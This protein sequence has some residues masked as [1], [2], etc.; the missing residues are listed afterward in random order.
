MASEVLDGRRLAD[1]LAEKVRERVDELTAAGLPAP[2]LATVLVGGDPASQ[3]YVAAK[4]RACARA[5]LR[6]F[7]HELPA[8]ATFAEVAGCIE[9]LNED[10]DVSGILLQ[11]PLPAGLRAERLIDLIDPA[12][13]VDGLSANNAGLV[14]QERPNLAPCTP[15]G[16]VLLLEQHGI[17]IEGMHVVIVG[18]SNLVGK[19]LASLLL[20][21]DATVTVC[22]HRTRDL[23]SLT[24]IADIVVAACG[25]PRLLGADAIR[26]GAVV[27]DVGITRLPEGLVG[28]V[29]F[30]AVLP[31]VR[32]I[33]PVPGGVGPM[34][35]ACLLVNTLRAAEAAAGRRVAPLLA[36]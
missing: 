31:K 5:G 35:V 30:A 27:I 26:E 29:D 3:V 19:P 25:V 6:S 4:H 17:E 7:N 9:G 21:R 15:D 1:I 13:D 32:A 16:V 10:P 34:T 12:K 28:D 36:G 24:R 14:A 18:R 23:E 11:L 33:T 2:G 22:H 20:A 8:D